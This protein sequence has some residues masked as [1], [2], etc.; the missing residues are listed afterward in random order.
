MKNVSDNGASYIKFF[1]M[2]I[3]SAIG[4]FFL[5]YT[6][7]YQVIDH[8]WFSETRLFMTIIMAGFMIIS[9]LLFMLKMYKNRILNGLIISSGLLIIVGG[10]ALV[11]SQITVT[12]VDY[13]EG[14]IPHHSIA[15]LTSDRAQIK[16]IR[17]RKLAN[18]I[19]KAQRRE[20]MEMQW[21]IIDIQTN[22]EVLADSLLAGREIPEFEGELKSETKNR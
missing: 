13:M 15:I 3:V 19:I 8:F 11:R 22:G 5:M 9:M 20:I 14:M 2:I 21:L 6:H 10:V 16:D 12:S 18:E 17:A 4:M 1:V 7:S